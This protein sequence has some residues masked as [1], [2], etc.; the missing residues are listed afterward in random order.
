[1]RPLAWRPRFI[2]LIGGSNKSDTAPRSISVTF[3]PGQ[4]V[5]TDIDRTKRIL[6]A[7]TA[8]KN[9]FALAD[10]R[11]GDSVCLI[12]TGPYRYRISKANVS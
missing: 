9:F 2:E 12:R 3:S 8:V 10:V 11:E 1:M 5:E 4:T 7:R 6:R